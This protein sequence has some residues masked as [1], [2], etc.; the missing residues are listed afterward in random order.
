MRSKIISSADTYYSK[1][2]SALIRDM[3]SFRRID[4][5]NLEYLDEPS[6]QVT[7]H[8]RHIEELFRHPS[9]EDPAELI[10]TLIDTV[11]TIPKQ[12]L[13]NR[14]MLAD[15]FVASASA[16]YHI[17]GMYLLL[18]CKLIST[19]PDCVCQKTLLEFIKNLDAWYHK[20]RSKIKDNDPF[21]RIVD[22]TAICFIR[23]VNLFAKGIQELFPDLIPANDLIVESLP[24]NFTVPDNTYI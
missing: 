8:F 3:E 21:E 16:Q 9:T 13:R 6:V 10:P 12:D 11:L 5:P 18:I 17:A 24:G 20:E 7:R 4:L 15:G 14:S 2:I 19:Q 22:Q 1:I 23:H